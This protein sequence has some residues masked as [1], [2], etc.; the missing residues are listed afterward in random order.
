MVFSFLG[1]YFFGRYDKTILYF[2]L[3]C[4]TYSYRI[5]GASQY[6]LHSFIPNVPWIVT[7]HLEYLTLF[8]SV[9]FFTQYTQKL[10][11]EDTNKYITTIEMWACII[12]SLITV[13]FP[14]AV[15]TQLIS[16]FLAVMFSVI[17]YAFY[18]Y[19]IAYRKKRLGAGYALLS[20]GVVML[21]FIIINLQ[22]FGYA[23]P[24]KELLFFGYISFFFLQSLI[25][26]YRYSYLL[27]KAKKEAEQG[28]LAK[29]DFLSN[30]SHEIRTPLNSVIGLSHIL[31]ENKPREDQK[32]QLNVLLF[33]ANNLLT[34]VNDILDYNKIE[35]G[36]I[37]FEYIDMD[38]V[39]VFQDLLSGMKA[40]ADE[41][42]YRTGA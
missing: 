34:I 27:N 18:V 37:N 3:F 31:L 23:A 39:K 40:I 4:I 1:L 19:I 24:Q 35:A 7:V 22:Y 25:L 8:V 5:V 20:T 42:K 12:L 2:A 10:Y 16:P 21:V 17:A 26:S 38:L 6:A 33:S 9:I 36:K 29:S 15:F 41:K 30:M 14:P 13:V 32:E 11:P 28:L